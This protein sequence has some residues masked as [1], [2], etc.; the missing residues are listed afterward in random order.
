KRENINAEVDQN[1]C[2]TIEAL[3]NDKECFFK[4]KSSTAFGILK[5]LDVPDES[6]VNMYFDLISPDNYKKNVTPQ[7]SI[8]IKK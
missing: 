3:L 7:R 4:M 5:Y 8:T 6:I 2:N 1:K